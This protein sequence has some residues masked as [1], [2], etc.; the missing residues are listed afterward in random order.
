MKMQDALKMASKVRCFI[1][2]SVFLACLAF[3]SHAMCDTSTEPTIIGPLLGDVVLEPGANFSGR[4]FAGTQLVRQ[5]LTGAQF[6]NADLNG[7]KFIE[8]MLK[9]AS[10]QNA[11]LTGAVFIETSL[12][13]ADFENATIT[14]CHFEWTLSPSQIKQTRSFREKNLQGV[15]FTRATLGENLDLRGFDLRKSTIAGGGDFRDVAFDGAKIAGAKIEAQ[16]DFEQ[17]RNA[18][19][20]RN[21]MFPAIYHAKSNCNLSK[22]D[23][24][25]AKL[26]FPPGVAFDLS[27]ANI[28]DCLIYFT[29]N[30]ATEATEAIEGT[31]SY[32]Q[33]RLRST[34][35]FGGNLSGI[36]FDNMILDRVFITRANFKDASFRNTVI[37]WSNLGVVENLLTVSQLRETYNVEHGLLSEFRFLPEA[38]KAE[39]FLKHKQP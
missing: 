23:L 33:G 5:D 20:V 14:D 3:A 36:N 17:L 4:N 38:L 6:S 12:F 15:R 24:R 35:I 13:N 21:G 22:L 39:L 30:E 18:V 29:T 27:D 25:G 37:V 32:K 9:D 34:A 11:S 19:E 7:A 16:V 2:I 26:H 8:C 10:F 1:G 28:D 31:W